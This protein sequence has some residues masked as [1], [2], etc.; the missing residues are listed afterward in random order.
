MLAMQ[1]DFLDAHER[2]WH[3]AELLFGRQRHANADHLYGMAAECGLKRLMLAFGMPFNR[4]KDRPAKRDD[5][6]HADGVWARFDSYRSG[7]THGAGYALPPDNLFADWDVGQR[8]AAQ[9]HFDDAHV[10]AHR[11]GAELV[12]RLIRKAIRE[13]HL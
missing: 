8:Y 11:T 4:E 2:H 1:A 13:G 9:H 10:A 5:Q 6:V 7:H 12:N 3:D